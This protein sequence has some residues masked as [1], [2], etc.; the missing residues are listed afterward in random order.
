[1]TLDDFFDKFDLISGAA[2]A[3]SQ[4]RS[5]VLGL[6]VRGRLVPQNPADDDAECLL[7]DIAKRFAL[8]IEE[9]EIADKWHE[10][11]SSWRWVRL[12]TIGKIVGGGTPRSDNPSF[13]SDTQGIPWLTPADLNGFSEKR[14]FR[15]RRFITPQGLG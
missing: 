11:P 6:A 12:G 2:D 9:Q 4:M 13:F 14:I 1:M 15:G 3:V 7:R 8:N 5:L 10:I